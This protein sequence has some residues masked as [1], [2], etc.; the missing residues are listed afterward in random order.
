MHALVVHS[1]L[2]LHPQLL[3]DFVEIFIFLGRED[4]G[5]NDAPMVQ[6]DAPVRITPDVLIMRYQQN[7]A[8]LRMETVQQI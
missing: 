4:H 2:S 1:A 6:V 7:G 5:L 8:A 3:E